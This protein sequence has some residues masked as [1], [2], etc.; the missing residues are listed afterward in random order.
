VDPEGKRVEV[1]TNYVN[2]ETAFRDSTGQLLNKDKKGSP[3]DA[4]GKPLKKVKGVYQD[5]AGN[6]VTKGFTDKKSETTIS[7]LKV[8]DTFDPAIKDI[9]KQNPA[10]AN[11]S[12]DLKKA[13]LD[14][15]T[16]AIK[17]AEVT[18]TTQTTTRPSTV[19]DKQTG[20][21]LPI[22]EKRTSSTIP[23]KDAE[24]RYLETTFTTIETTMPDGSISTQQITKLRY[25][26]G[27]G[28]AK[29]K[30]EQALTAAQGQ[31]QAF[32]K[33]FD[34]QPVLQL[35]DFFKLTP[36]KLTKLKQNWTDLFAEK[37]YLN[38]VLQTKLPQGRISGINWK[39][40]TISVDD[41]GSYK[42]SLKFGAETLDISK[43]T[44]SWADGKPRFGLREG[45]FKITTAKDVAK[46][47]TSDIKTAQTTTEQANLKQ[48]NKAVVDADA[49]AKS[50][51]LAAENNQIDA[52]KA[53]AVARF[54][55]QARH[56]YQAALAADYRYKRAAPNSEAANS[57]S[58]A[59]ATNTSLAAQA[60][61]E[62]AKLAQP[63]SPYPTEQ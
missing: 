10:Y 56:Y 54:A 49:M 18:V 28:K 12:K 14:D 61:A 20:Y 30:T 60:A 17:A 48:A 39:N 23:S 8:S 51:T 58:E 9:L 62:A 24:G 25:P 55:E 36:H 35:G 41:K 43:V 26:N 57:A 63:N 27:D 4:N 32:K 16:G 7:K 13:E 34:N 6:P 2:G 15:K 21:Y 31:P 42:L 3:L 29:T 19:K 37:A 33:V 11:I 1:V 46:N 52:A 50:M 53:Q 45:E 59:V 5:S 44:L 22:K 47:L 38:E 40:S